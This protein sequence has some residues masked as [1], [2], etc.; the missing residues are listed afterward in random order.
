MTDQRRHDGATATAGA[1]DVLMLAFGAEPYLHE[2][3][4]AVLAS[5]GVD[6][7]LTLVDNGCTTDA[8]ATLPP[9][10]RVRLV[11]PGSN[12]GFTGGMNT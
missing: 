8:V 3:V 9:D 12:L 5:E 1:A 7:R 10:P 4:A 11:V 6:V 2:A